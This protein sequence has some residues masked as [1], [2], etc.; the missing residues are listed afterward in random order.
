METMIHI[1]KHTVLLRSK[2]SRRIKRHMNCAEIVLAL[3]Y[4][5]VKFF[6]NYIYIRRTMFQQPYCLSHPFN[7]DSPVYHSIITQNTLD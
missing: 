7:E 4:R 3:D 1:Y 5:L 6:L 2:Y